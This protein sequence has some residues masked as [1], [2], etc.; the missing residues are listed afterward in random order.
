MLWVCG[1]ELSGNKPR[2]AESDQQMW[3]S[4]LLTAITTIDNSRL[5]KCPTLKSCLDC[6]RMAPKR[7]RSVP[8]DKV[9][10][11]KVL[12]FGSLQMIDRKRGHPHFPITDS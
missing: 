2:F 9:S 8:P 1:V 6:R 12:L 3:V 7:Y 5:T 4:P 10:I 11:A